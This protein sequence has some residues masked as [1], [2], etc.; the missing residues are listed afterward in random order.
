MRLPKDSSASWKAVYMHLCICR[1]MCVSVRECW[2]RGGRLSYVTGR[3]AGSRPANRGRGSGDGGGFSTACDSTSFTSERG[4]QR[5]GYTA[6]GLTMTLKTR[7]L[8][9]HTRSL[10]GRSGLMVNTGRPP[11][12]GAQSYCLGQDFRCVFVCLLF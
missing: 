12:A 9:T 8:W 1:C 6:L 3:L 5:L 4:S 10:C 2:G 7:G 11:V